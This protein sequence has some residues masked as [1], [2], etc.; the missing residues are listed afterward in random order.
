MLLDLLRAWC[1]AL[2]NWKAGS[3][4]CTPV[5]VAAEI[6]NGYPCCYLMNA[7]FSG[8]QFIDFSEYRR[9][10]PEGDVPLVQVYP[11]DFEA[12]KG[13]ERGDRLRFLAFGATPI[14]GDGALPL[15]PATNIVLTIVKEGWWIMTVDDAKRILAARDPSDA[16]AGGLTKNGTWLSTVEIVADKYGLVESLF[17]ICEEVVASRTAA[18]VI[19]TPGLPRPF[20]LWRKSLKGIMPPLPPL[21]P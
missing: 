16:S 13:D 17:P 15:P 8:V 1:Q 10:S 9:L 20:R 21:A 4:Q 14:R 19:F 7:A 2:H 6:I 12:L 3:L 5:A 18:M 11:G